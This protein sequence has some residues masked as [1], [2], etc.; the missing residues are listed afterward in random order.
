VEYV[1]LS[2]L[3]AVFVTIR[4][5]RAG[6]EQ[7][8]KRT[9]K[10]FVA[11]LIVSAISSA[12]SGL[13]IQQQPSRIIPAMIETDL[14]NYQ[15]KDYVM[16]NP[17]GMMKFR[18]Q[19]YAPS[20]PGDS[21]LRQA[22]HPYVNTQNYCSN[23]EVPMEQVG[24]IYRP[25][26]NDWQKLMLPKGLRPL[27]AYTVPGFEGIPD[28]PAGNPFLNETIEAAIKAREVGSITSK[29]SFTIDEAYQLEELFIRN[30]RVYADAAA[31]E[32]AQEGDTAFV[33]AMKE[34][35]DDSISFLRANDI[36]DDS[37]IIDPMQ[38]IEQFVTDYFASVTQ[39]S[40]IMSLNLSEIRVEY[41]VFNLSTQINFT[42]VTVTVRQNRA[43]WYRVLDEVDGELVDSNTPWSGLDELIYEI[44]VAR[45]C[46]RTTCAVQNRGYAPDPHVSSFGD[47]AGGYDCTSA[48]L[49]F[50]HLVFGFARR[51]EGDSFELLELDSGKSGKLRKAVV[52]NPRDSHIMT[53]GCIMI[54]PED[55]SI[56]FNANCS[57]EDI[58]CSGISYELATPE[59]SPKQFLTLQYSL[60]PS[61][62]PGFDLVNGRTGGHRLVSRFTYG[63]RVRY[64][65]LREFNFLHFNYS[66]QYRENCSMAMDRYTIDAKFNY[67]YQD[68][69]LQVTYTVAMFHLFQNA[70]LTE[71]LPEGKGDSLAFLG[72]LEL[73][74]V[75]I[76]LPSTL[77]ALACFS[78]SLIA[79]IIL[80]ALKYIDLMNPELLRQPKLVLEA[81]MNDSDF[82]RAMLHL[83]V[84]AH[85][86]G[87]TTP[88]TDLEVDHMEFAHP[89]K[90]HPTVR[91]HTTM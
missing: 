55:L 33:S 35:G 18:T 84:Q 51:I 57:M 52:R 32:A 34:L 77:F 38:H 23:T 64:E 6:H 31:L 17:D 66:S 9:P 39:W 10:K 68:H 76:M 2:G 89:N 4:S 50:S 75:S 27:E 29:T 41:A 79:L 67:V 80:R 36:H 25:Y 60:I 26:R 46:A 19:E 12:L 56:K 3:V 45:E 47:C 11:I 83:D 7:W 24:V 58:S 59:G 74:G 22:M 48:V 43:L 63:G 16:T 73:I 61:E 71:Q 30:A 88:L 54:E 72:N 1:S 40:T 90:A 81:Y 42:S 87:P 86:G 82:P 53:M 5:L 28:L 15:E 44:P 62:M 91:F 65:F 8:Q 21:I 20:S 37:A 13:S 70:K 78:C 85:P 49:A 14:R 69:P